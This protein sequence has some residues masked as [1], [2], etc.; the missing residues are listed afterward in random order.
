MDSK[1]IPKRKIFNW[2]DEA[3][4]LLLLKTQG[5]DLSELDPNT[6][7]KQNTSRPVQIK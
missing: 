5:R 6:T 4:A 3:T 7:Q 2:R 1:V